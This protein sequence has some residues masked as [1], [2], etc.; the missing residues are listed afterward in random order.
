MK[1]RTNKEE[2]DIKRHEKSNEWSWTTCNY[3]KRKFDQE[4]KAR[5][6]RSVC[7]ITEYT[8]FYYHIRNRIKTRNNKSW[9]VIWLRCIC[10]YVCMFVRRKTAGNY[11]PNEYKLR[12]QRMKILP[13]III[14][15]NHRRTVFYSSAAV[16]YRR[17]ILLPVYTHARAKNNKKKVTYHT[18]RL[19][20]YIHSSPTT[21]IF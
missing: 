5:T 18:I 4:T 7:R 3:F 1:E 11:G 14:I 16:R 6:V 2:E 20:Y 12:F 10:M 13:N 15:I 21:N 8:L 17:S 9:S 19:Y